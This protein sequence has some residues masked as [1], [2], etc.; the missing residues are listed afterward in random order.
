M[1]YTLSFTQSPKQWNF[2]FF[3]GQESSRKLSHKHTEHTESRV[4][5][6]LSAKDGSSN[7]GI[8]TH[9][10]LLYTVKS[11]LFPSEGE[12]IWTFVNGEFHMVTGQ[13]LV[14]FLRKRVC[15]PAGCPPPGADRRGLHTSALPRVGVL[16]GAG[17]TA[18]GL[19]WQGAMSA[20]TAF[21]WIPRPRLEDRP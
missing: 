9:E 20:F 12:G 19:K 1:S 7:N 11:T 3:L 18:H 15:S 13:I 21:A 4:S 2:A 5:E 16:Q 6:H 10:T 17:H 14:K 8:K